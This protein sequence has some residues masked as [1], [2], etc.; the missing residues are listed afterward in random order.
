MRTSRARWVRSLPILAVIA[1]VAGGCTDDGGAP[2]SASGG[3]EPDGEAIESQEVTIVA[4]DYAFTEA[5]VEL[6]SG[7][8]QLHFENHGTVPHEIVLDGIGDTPLDQVVVGSRGLDFGDPF[9]E[10]IDQVVIPTPV[11]AKG[12]EGFDATFT[13]SEGRYALFCN[14]DIAPKG[15]KKTRHLDLG[16]IRELTVVG[17][18]GGLELPEADGTITAS[19][20]AFDIDLEAGDRTVNFLN[21]GPDEVH[22]A[23]VELY[24]EDVSAEE[25]EEAYALRLEPG[26]PPQ[27]TPMAEAGL[28][29]SGIFSSGLG[30]TFRLFDGGAFESGRTY[31]FVCILSD[32]A[33]G[34]P[35]AKAY[36]MYEAVT[37]E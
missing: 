24:T 32:R 3:S 1:M 19:D 27:G 4:V 20:H 10:F 18:D 7:V 31:L 14:L 34:D 37:I 30:S 17:G 29:F 12:G 15:E 13:L 36:G 8:I 2:A 5:P 11:S 16:M 9:P 23:T 25:A 35:H 21:E 26:K 22:V 6:Q 33:G 28:G